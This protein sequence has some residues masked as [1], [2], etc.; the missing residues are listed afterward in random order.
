MTP[1]EEFPEILFASNNPHKLHEVREALK[2]FLQVRSLQEKGFSG[3]I[4]ETGMT[5]EDN[6]RIKAWHVYQLFGQD[7]FADDTG[8]EVDG[9]H[10]APGVFSARYAGEGCSFADNVRKLLEEMIEIRNRQAKFRT[11]ICLIISGKEYFF[12]GVVNG[13]ILL[14]QRGIEG[15]GY[16][17]VFLPH[18]FTQSFAEMSME[19]K[20]QISHR[21]QALLLL[22][23]F[24][25]GGPHT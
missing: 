14:E 10:G 6:A 23:D 7:C 9:L 19:L 20:N 3:D 24:L 12:E 15:F 8:L 4:P 2:G 5:L 16:D 22:T 13:E 21:G 25:R 1:F 11:V 17:P 18:G